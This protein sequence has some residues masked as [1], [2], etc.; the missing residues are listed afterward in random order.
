MYI[1]YILFMWL[2]LIFR[3]ELLEAVFHDIASGNDADEGVFVVHHRHEVLAAGSMYQF[4]HTGIDP[5]RNIIFTA[6]D[7]HDAAGFCKTDVH[8]THI[9]QGPQQVTFR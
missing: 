1:T 5:D 6:G 9:F 4:V 2:L 8:I 3:V 7:L